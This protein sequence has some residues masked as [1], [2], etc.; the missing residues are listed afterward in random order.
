MDIIGGNLMTRTEERKK[1]RQTLQDIESQYHLLQ[2]LFE[3]TNIFIH[4]LDKNGR[5]LFTNPIAINRLGYTEDELLKQNYVDFLTPSS[6]KQFSEQF[7]NLLEEKSTR[8]QLEIIGNDK[9]VITLESYSFAIQNEQGEVTALVFF[10]NVITEHKRIEEALRDAKG[11]YQMLVEKLHEGVLLED[12]D[13][14]ITFVNPRMS[15]ILEYDEEELVGW[16]FSTIVPAEEL[17]NVQKEAEKRSQG[18]ISNFETALT[19]NDGS[20]IPVIISSTPLFTDTAEFLGVLSVVTDITARKRV[21]ETLKAS[22]EQY[23]TTI[24]SM[25]DAIHVI[26]S[27]LRIILTNIAFKEQQKNRRLDPDVIGKTVFEAFPF[28]PDKVFEEYLQVYDREKTL[29]TEQSFKVSDKEHIFDVRMIPIPD[30][31]GEIHRVVTVAR[32][33][34]ESRQAEQRLRESEQK[35]RLLA[36]ASLVGITIAQENQHKYVNDALAQ[37]VG[38]SREEMLTWTTSEVPM[39]IYP[40]DLPFVKEQW[41]KKESGEEEGVIPR[42]QFRIVTKTNDLKWV[43]VFSHIIQFDGKPALLAAYIDITEQKRVEEELQYQL[44]VSHSL[45]EI[46]ARF[47][48]FMSLDEAINITLKD[49]G[50]L[51]FSDRSFI[52]LYEDNY[53]KISNKYEWCTLKEHSVKHKLMDLSNDVLERWFY[54]FQRGESISIQ[55]VSLLSSEKENERNFLEKLKIRSLIAYPL[56]LG[57]RISGFL[58]IVDI[59]KPRNWIEEDVRILRICAEIIGGAMVRERAEAANLRLVHELR[60]AN[61]ALKDFAFVVSH[62]LRAPLRGIAYLTDWIAQDYG[63]KFDNEGKERIDLLLA[64]VK[65]MN[66]LIDGILQYSQVGRVYEKKTNIDLEKLISEVIELLNPPAHK[67]AI[68]F[69]SKLPILYCEK[70]RISQI[71]QNLIDNAIK[72]MDKPHGEIRVS[73]IDKDDF[74]ELIVADNGPG[75]EEG[76]FKKV[77]QIFQKAASQNKAESTGIGLALIKKIIEQEGGRIWVESIIGKGSKFHFTI[78]KRDKGLKD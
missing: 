52:F 51:L 54:Y 70:T 50:E 61:E 16:H 12:A 53:R 73:C 40:D 19:A 18:Q 4:I 74:W 35:F 57:K 11:K 42:H 58:G 37:I 28:S 32:D 15:E 1:T 25:N 47:V 59:Q 72:F 49:I 17:D 63:D 55:D 38:Y 14:F 21:L 6:Q 7:V 20:T 27:D 48:S 23:R 62:D 45:S 64:R 9:S 69:E 75:I 78:P 71:F 41:K 24:D 34:T 77:F 46:S 5:I 60:Q 39:P 13:G 31:S 68:I 8:Q 67:F 3:S 56:F 22:E 36:E 2:S 30:S 29:I 65:W 33:I 43:E 44:R 66:A 10:Q 26:D 76:D